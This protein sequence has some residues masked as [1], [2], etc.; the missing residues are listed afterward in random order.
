MLASRWLHPFPVLSVILV[1]FPALLFWTH[2]PPLH[3]QFMFSCYNFQQAS[4]H[5]SYLLS[6]FHQ[7]YYHRHI[8]LTQQRALTKLLEEH[9]QCSPFSCNACE[10]ITQLQTIPE[11]T[12]IAQ[13][14]DEIVWSLLWSHYQWQGASLSQLGKSF[15]YLTFEKMQCLQDDVMING[16]VVLIRTPCRTAVNSQLSCTELPCY[17]RSLLLGIL[18]L[19]HL[20]RSPRQEC[21]GN[22]NFKLNELNLLR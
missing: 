7:S 12:I 18:W 22:R 19:E 4:L 3:V 1:H 21:V 10:R 17:C 14:H 15:P 13:L 8:I 16:S 6:P 5:N 9:I 20:H 11:S 2:P